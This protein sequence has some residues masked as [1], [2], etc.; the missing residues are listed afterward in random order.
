MA[1]LAAPARTV[2]PAMRDASA[3]P[4]A[5][6]TIALVMT[7]TPSNRR[8]TRP[9]PMLLMPVSIYDSFG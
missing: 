3:A 7:A 6:A 5:D 4:A 2:V 9:F 1:R 8:T